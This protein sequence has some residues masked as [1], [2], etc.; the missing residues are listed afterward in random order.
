[1]TLCCL[2]VFASTGGSI[3]SWYI[4]VQEYK[5]INTQHLTCNLV[6]YLGPITTSFNGAYAALDDQ[7]MQFEFTRLVISLFGR[8]LLDRPISFSKKQYTYFWLKGELAC[9]RSSG[10]GVVLLKRTSTANV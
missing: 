1:M 7:N 10:G 3:W 6:S 4:P 2:Q 9:A 8:K 5:D